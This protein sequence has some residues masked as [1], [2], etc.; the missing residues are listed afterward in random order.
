VKDQELQNI[1]TV[2]DNEAAERATTRMIRRMGYLCAGVSGG[3]EGLE[4]LQREHFDIVLSD[5]AMTRMNGIEFMHKAK[6][7]SWTGRP[8]R[9]GRR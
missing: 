6:V 5:I 9:V 2:D 4:R 8:K 7:Y 3:E 1:L